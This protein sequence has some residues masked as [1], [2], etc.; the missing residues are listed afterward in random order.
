MSEQVCK[1]ILCTAEVDDDDD[2]LTIVYICPG[3]MRLDGKSASIHHS[4]TICYM[5]AQC[6]V[7][8]F[9]D[10]LS[11]TLSARRRSV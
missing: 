6:P 1:L 5:C 8:V 2:E 3:V 10:I 9:W 11:N 7:D 4:K